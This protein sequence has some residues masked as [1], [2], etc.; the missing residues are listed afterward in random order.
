[1]PLYFDGVY[2]E[3]STYYSTLNAVALSLFGFVSALAGG[4]VSVHYYKKGEYMSKAYVCMFCSIMGI[5]TIAICLLFQKSFALSMSMLALGYLLAEGFVG[6][7]ITMVINVISPENKGFAVSVFLF[8]CTVAGTIS[9]LLLGF[10]QDQYNAKENRYLYG[11]ILCAFVVFSYA[12]SLP[13]FY[14]AGRC[15]TT[16]KKKEDE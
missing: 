16:F 15:Y 7:A 14:L 2:E 11:Y 3:Y 12:G 5:P 10:L 8:C 1:M 6:P 13:F 9:T 4:M